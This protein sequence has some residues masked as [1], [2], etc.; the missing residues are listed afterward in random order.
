MKVKILH[1]AQLRKISIILTKG[2]TS[3]FDMKRKE[4]R[5]LVCCFNLE[6]SRI[7]Y[8][9]LSNNLPHLNICGL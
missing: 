8:V 2:L 1:H 3:N 4:F 7:F 9:D 6:F 5:D